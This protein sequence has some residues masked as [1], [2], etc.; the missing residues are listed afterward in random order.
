M[1]YLNGEPLMMTDEGTLPDIVPKIKKLERSV[2][3][4]LPPYSI[5]FWVVPEAKVKFN[6][7]QIPAPNGHS[8]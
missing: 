8:F 1:T 6:R 7:N 2:T 4:K 3:M 5:G